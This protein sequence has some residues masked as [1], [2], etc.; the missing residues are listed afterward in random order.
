MTGEAG[1]ADRKATLEHGKT[2]DDRK[3]AVRSSSAAPG[4]SGEASD[5]GVECLNVA[6]AVAVCGGEHL[7]LEICRG[8]IR[9]GVAGA[10]GVSNVAAARKH[11]PVRDHQRGAPLFRWLL[12]DCDF[13]E[14]GEGL[15]AQSVHRGAGIVAG[16][17]AD[18]FSDAWP[19]DARISIA[20]GLDRGE[21]A[22]A[23]LALDVRARAAVPGE[24]LMKLI[25][26]VFGIAIVLIVIWVL[27]WLWMVA[28]REKR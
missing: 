17:C 21:F 20:A 11:R 24:A 28:T 26:G 23:G 18:R 8:G 16:E 5:G 22:D 6:G 13:L 27:L 19:R 7:S 10:I 9:A 15:P 12:R 4:G 14:T 25:V 3:R 1:D 2:A